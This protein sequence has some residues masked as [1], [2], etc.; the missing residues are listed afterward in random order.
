MTLLEIGTQ[1]A[2]DIVLSMINKQLFELEKELSRL[3]DE[4]AKAEI[5]Y[6]NLEIRIDSKRDQR[7]QLENSRDVLIKNG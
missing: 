3:E 5:I 6:T 4:K 1:M 7:A 2:D